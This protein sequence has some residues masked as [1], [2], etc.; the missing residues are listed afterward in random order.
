MAIHNVKRSRVVRKRLRS[1]RT[2]AEAILWKSLK[3]SQLDGKKFRRQHSVGPYV[4]DFYC[5]ECR[6]AI[7][8]DGAGHSDLL[9]AEYDTKRTHFLNSKDIQVLRLENSDILETGELVLEQI[10]Q[11][12]RTTLYEI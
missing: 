11:T 10:R 4:L 12:L 9:T 7:E 5:P 6:L 8:L 2:A 3:N 1:S